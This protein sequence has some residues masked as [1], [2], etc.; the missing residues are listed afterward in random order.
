MNLGVDLCVFQR[1]I[2]TVLLLVKSP[3]WARKAGW[4][5]GVGWGWVFTGP[6]PT[7]VNPKSSGTNFFLLNC[8][9]CACLRRYY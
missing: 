9:S 1:D 8:E 3:N 6:I 5:W 7:Y 4:G 2:G